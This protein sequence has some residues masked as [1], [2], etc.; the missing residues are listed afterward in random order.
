MIYCL[1]MTMAMRPLTRQ[2]LRGTWATV[3]LPLA[4]D[5]SIDFGRLA[6]ELSVLL[7]AGLDGIYTNGT[8]GEFHALE[9]E[10]YDRVTRVVATACAAAGQAFQLGAGHMS[11]QTSLRRIRTNSTSRVNAASSGPRSVI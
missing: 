9:E 5:D 10:E 6:D 7:G 11:G 4:G 8:A 1:H 2:T 3:L